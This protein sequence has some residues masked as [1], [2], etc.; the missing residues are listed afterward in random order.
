MPAEREK[1]QLS[2]V[3]VEDVAHFITRAGASVNSQDTVTLRPGAMPRKALALQIVYPKLG[4]ELVGPEG[5]KWCLRCRVRS[6]STSACPGSVV[7]RAVE[8][9]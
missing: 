6:P 8:A 4:H 7:S 2:Q 9:I 5:A 1:L 3:L